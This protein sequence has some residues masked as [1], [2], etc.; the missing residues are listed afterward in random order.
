[1]NPWGM[2]CNEFVEVVT[3]YL[4]GK[5]GEED[6]AKFE[7]HL[8]LCESCV[9]Y[10]EQMRLTLRATG[11]LGVEELAPEALADLLNVF[12]QWKQARS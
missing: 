10:V 5:L 7:K 11:R 1:M 9:D 8:A 12:R 2:D 3:E 4:E 6:R